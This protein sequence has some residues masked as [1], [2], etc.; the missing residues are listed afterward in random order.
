MVEAEDAG[1]LPGAVFIFPEVEEFG[2]TGVVVLLVG[3]M[4]AVCAGF[5]GAVFVDGEDF[6][7]AGDKFAGDFAAD[8]VLDGF[9]D[10]SASAG[11]PGDVVVELQVFVEERAESLEVAVVVGVEEFGVERLDGFE[12]IFWVG[13]GGS[14]GQDVGVGCEKQ[15]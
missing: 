13:C 12:E 4:K 11:K 15:N 3:V 7:R 10:G 6:E 9:D 1:E 5:D 8:V 2:F 14:L